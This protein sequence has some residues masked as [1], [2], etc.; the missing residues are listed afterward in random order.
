MLTISNQ[1]SFLIFIQDMTDHSSMLQYLSS[2]LQSKDMRAYL[3]GWPSGNEPLP[4]I[5][6]LGSSQQESKMGKIS[7]PDETPAEKL[8]FSGERTLVFNIKSTI[9]KL[10]VDS[11]AYSC[12]YAST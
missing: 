2:A 1:L 3:R 9:V 5:I 11:W 7:H 6:M 10:Q 4:P 8:S 12:F